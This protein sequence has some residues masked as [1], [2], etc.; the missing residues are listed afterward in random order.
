MLER[1]AKRAVGLSSPESM[2]VVCGFDL[3][4]G[5]AA[6]VS[7]L[8]RENILLEPEG[9]NTAPCVGLAAL[10]VM[11]RDPKGVMAVMP[12]DHLIRDEEGFRQAL[13]T[14]E[15]AATG[16]AIVTLGIKPTRPETGYGYIKVGDEVEPVGRHR[17]HRADQF[18]EKPDKERAEGFVRTGRYLWNSGVFVWRADAIMKAFET[19]LPEVFKGLMEVEKAL[20]GDNYQEA[21]ERAYARFPSISIDRGVVE[22]ADNVLVIPCD[23]GW[24]DVGTWRALMGVSDKDEKGNAISARHVGIDTLRCMI[25]SDIPRKLVATIGLED[26]IVV[27]TEDV[28]LICRMERDQDVREIVETLKR[29]GLI[30][31]L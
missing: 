2:F 5:V 9:K 24:S 19:L 26:T 25:H 12:S 10:H 28:L 21:L 29:K 1:T 17:V 31:Y 6:S 14:A 27:E 13:R 15:S 30:E 7:W 20:G 22:R 23:L 16:G 11:K 3:L 4:E 18:V 8:P